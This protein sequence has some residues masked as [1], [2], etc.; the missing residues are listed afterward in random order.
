VRVGDLVQV[1]F[2]R[3]RSTDPYPVGIL[4]DI[5]RNEYPLQGE[6]ELDYIVLVDGAERKMRK[7]WLRAIDETG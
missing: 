3:R 6:T 7:R 4:V 2:R 1:T 5:R